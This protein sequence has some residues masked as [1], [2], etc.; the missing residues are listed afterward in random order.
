MCHGGLK[1]LGF[2]DFIGRT[3]TALTVCDIPWNRGVCLYQG[4]YRECSAGG[5]GCGSPDLGIGGKGS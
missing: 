3:W 5:V 2:G 1:G 4:G